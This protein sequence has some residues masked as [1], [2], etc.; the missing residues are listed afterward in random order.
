MQTS[1]NHFEATM[2]F[3]DETITR[4]F[5]TEY[6]TYE[7]MRQL[8]R[9]AVAVAL[10]A[11]ALFGGL[12]TPAT[13]LCLLAGGFLAAAKNLHSDI[14]AERVLQSRGGA[15]STVKCRFNDGGIELDNGQHLNYSAVDRLVE[16]SDYFYLFQNR[17]NAV[18]VP[19]ATLLPASPDRFR[20]FVAGET[21]KT[22][23][24][25]KPMGLLNLKD[26][27][28]MI[29]DKAGIWLGR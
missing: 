5:R 2:V 9:M 14:Q 23:T 12:P 29:R 21:G 13:V 19:K 16:D 28:Q 18:M 15:E 8:T 17:Q 4:L 24:E 22:W 1:R 26:L 11:L 3:N 20:R 10:L 27:R 25:H 7:R 6:G